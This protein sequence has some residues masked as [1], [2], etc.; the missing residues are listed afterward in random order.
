MQLNISG[1]VMPLILES[2]FHDA[3]GIINGTILFVRLVRIFKRRCK[4]QP[5]WPCDVTGTLHQH[6]V[7][8]MEAL[9]LFHESKENELHYDVWSC[10]DL[11]LALALRS[12]D[13]IVNGTIAF[14]SSDNQNEVHN[15]TFLVM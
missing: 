11:V 5:F 2:M 8:S 1:H 14:I 6:H 13:R 9:H 4:L 10:D 12:A 3:N 15:K 7:M